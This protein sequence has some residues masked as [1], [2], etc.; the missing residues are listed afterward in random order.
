MSRERY[1]RHTTKEQAA[2][3][4]HLHEISLPVSEY[5]KKCFFIPNS[6]LH[7]AAAQSEVLKKAGVPVRALGTYF[8]CESKSEWRDALRCL[9]DARTPGWLF[10]TQT[11]L[12]SGA[13][14]KKEL[15]LAIR[16]L[17]GEPLKNA[18]GR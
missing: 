13:V 11:F 2:A 15:G 9:F 7:E 14:T 18:S 12:Q 3:V 6:G 5:R 8:C 17:V 4:T 10:H 1:F 16:E